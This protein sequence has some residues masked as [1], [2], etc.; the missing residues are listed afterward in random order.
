MESWILALPLFI[1]IL[2]LTAVVL[3]CFKRWKWAVGVLVVAFIVNWYGEV[4]ALHPFGACSSETGEKE[5]T[6]MTF[7]IHGSG[8][9]FDKRIAGIA[10]LIR[11]ENPDVVF[12][13]EIFTPYK[14]F[15][16]QL[17]SILKVSYPYSTY[18]GQTQWGN[19]FYS[20]HPIDSVQVLNITIG[21]CLPLASISVKGKN[22]TL[23]G[24]H[25]SSN[26]YVDSKTKLEVDDISTRGEAKQYFATLEKGYRSRRQDVDSLAL[27]LADM[28]MIHLIALGDMNDIGGSYTI[29]TF[30]AMG[31]KDAWWKGGFGLG[32]T[33]KV[34][35]F[36]FRIDH[37]MYGDGFHLNDV[38]VVDTDVLSD[39]E[40]VL[41]RFK[42]E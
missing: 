36:P 13:C 1:F 4:F 5:L 35:R 7:N 34:F 25:L 11:E 24:C 20:K 17:D 21:K 29:R 27:Q 16:Q 6:V 28:D 14:H 32:G 37:I 18:E 33:R 40:A 15:D 26:N 38:K 12:L 22:V 42:I 8:E 31:L 3:A 39:H 9:D 19:A 23:L 10:E 2:L 41:A 30:E